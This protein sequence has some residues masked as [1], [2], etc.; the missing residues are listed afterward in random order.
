VCWFKKILSIGN[1]C[2]LFFLVSCSELREYDVEYT[3]YRVPT[4]GFRDLKFLGVSRSH[5]IGSGTQERLLSMLQRCGQY[6]R[7]S[8]LNRVFQ[9]G[10]E[11]REVVQK[12][13]RSEVE[14]FQDARYVHGVLVIEQ[15]ESQVESDSEDI[16][17]VSI[18]DGVDH[19]WF[20]SFGYTAR[21]LSPIFGFDEIGPKMAFKTHEIKQK[22]FL[23]SVLWRFVLYN[24]TKDSILIDRKVKMAIRLKNY[25]S[26]PRI[27]EKL[28][29]NALGK[30]MMEH[31][32]G[33]V[34]PKIADVERQLL[35]RKE[36][37]KSDDLINVGIDLAS[38]DKWEAAAN[39]WKKA[40]L[41]DKNSAT[42]YHNLG[43]YYEKFGNIPAAME[44]F[45]KA[46]NSGQAQ[47]QPKF[48]DQAVNLY[49]PKIA[50]P[51]N[52]MRIYGVGSAQWALLMG[53]EKKNYEMG[54]EYPLYRLNRI[55]SKNEYMY[56]G[57]EFIEV[58]KI[59]II[60]QEDPFV[61]GRITQFV[62]STSVQ[63][64]DM[65][66]TDIE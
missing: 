63:N 44:E 3:I 32:S 45:L 16:K 25:S 28:I 39:Q 13:L 50:I 59:R 66:L 21:P 61:L 37:T 47:Y 30:E 31:I 15:L 48:Y 41:V 35:A 1:L 26:K 14:S 65:M 62:E 10:K 27:N 54:R 33:F 4:I 6:Q 49:R 9:V 22:K 29:E 18:K 55:S 58:G 53:G 46:K 52:D 12:K 60:K 5:K 38:D 24:K 56:H 43:I 57:V 11:D 8:R 23:K 51:S 34:C 7:V 20:Q 40:V 42:A 36:D 19:Q 17:L 64:G 2:A